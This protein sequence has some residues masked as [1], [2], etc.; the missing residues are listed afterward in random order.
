MTMSF[1]AHH[2]LKFQPKQLLTSFKLL[3]YSR[4][5]IICNSALR[6]DYANQCAHY[7]VVVPHCL[8]IVTQEQKFLQQQTKSSKKLI[9]MKI[10]ISLGLHQHMIKFK[11][12]NTRMTAIEINNYFMLLML[13]RTLKR[14][15]NE[16]HCQ[17]VLKLSRLSFL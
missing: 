10:M 5:T 14:N 13:V 7:R 4:D 16:K 9:Q 15:N 3:S 17:K 6:V 11:K 1:L 12:F 2:F 8:S